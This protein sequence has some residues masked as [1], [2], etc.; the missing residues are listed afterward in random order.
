MG[1][2]VTVWCAVRC[3]ELLRLTLASHYLHYCSWRMT[4]LLE[5]LFAA[6]AQTITLS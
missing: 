3:H 5:C 4:M 2:C 6:P 1:K